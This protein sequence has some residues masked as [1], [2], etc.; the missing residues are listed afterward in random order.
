MGCESQACSGEGAC[1]LIGVVRGVA[2]SPPNQRIQPTALSSFFVGCL[3]CEGVFIS[4]IHRF[5]RAAA[6]SLMSA[7]SPKANRCG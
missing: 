3:V 6:K 1:L 7:I 4:F 2:G 5:S